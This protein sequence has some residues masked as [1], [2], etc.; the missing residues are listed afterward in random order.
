MS[1]VRLTRAGIV[2]TEMPLEQRDLRIGRASDNDV[3]LED[4]DK[5]LSRH[6]A[7]VRSEGGRWFYLDL[8]SANGSWVGDRRVAREELT[9]GVAIALGDYQLAVIDEAQGAAPTPDDVNAT[10]V[11]RMRDTAVRPGAVPAAAMGK[12]AADAP[13][14]VGGAVS[15]GAAPVMRTA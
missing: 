14:A 13:P 9:A 12:P 3:V 1:T 6:H 7:E 15:V 8:N 5:T 11:I 2:E 10:R 4:P